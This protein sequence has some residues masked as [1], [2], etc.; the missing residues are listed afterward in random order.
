MMTLRG[1]RRG[2]L[3]AALAG[4]L[5]LAASAQVAVATD[6]TVPGTEPAGTEPAGRSAADRQRGADG[7]GTGL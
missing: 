7:V 5:F 3:T 6:T 2:K 1:S 4:T